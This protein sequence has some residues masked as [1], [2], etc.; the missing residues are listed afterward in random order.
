MGVQEPNPKTGEDEIM[1]LLTLE[2]RLHERSR[3]RR[4]PAVSVQATSVKRS[5][6]GPV[7]LQE[8]KPPPKGNA[9]TALAA[10]AAATTA[11]ASSTASASVPSTP[12]TS[13]AS[14]FAARGEEG[15]DEMSGLL[16]VTLMEARRLTGESMPLPSPYVVFRAGDSFGN[17]RSIVLEDTAAPVSS[18]S[19]QQHSSSS[20]SFS[21]SFHLPVADAPTRHNNS[22]TADAFSAGVL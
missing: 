2:A 18:Q 9:A 11:T 6:V 22:H 12:S 7:Y 17:V 19:C 14:A 13:T 8:R 21:C 5:V 15:S 3:I 16:K 20:L 1:D 4:V 10:A